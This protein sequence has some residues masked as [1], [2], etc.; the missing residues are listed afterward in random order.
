MSVSFDWTLLDDNTV[1]S[2]FRVLE[3]CE[4]NSCDGIAERMSSLLYI[5]MI[6]W[7]RHFDEFLTAG[8]YNISAC[9]EHQTT[10]LIRNK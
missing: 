8:K 7:L 5:C 3:M 6:S 9:A 2:L 10:K 1:A 4:E